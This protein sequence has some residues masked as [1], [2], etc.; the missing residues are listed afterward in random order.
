MPSQTE[1]DRRYKNIRSRMASA[2]LDVLIICGNQYAGFE[3]AVFYASGFEIVHRYVYVLLPLEGEPTLVFPREARWIGDKAKP[4]VKDQ[5]WPDVP[6][7][8]IRDRAKQRRWKRVGVYGMNFIMAVR[9]YRE[10]VQASLELVPFDFE[11]DM[12]RAVKS[13]EELVE[14]R[15]AMDIIVEGF[16]ALVDAYEP[17]KTE[18]EIMAPA[19]ERFFARGAGPRMMNIVLSGAHGQAEAHF[20]VPS[21]RAV[22]SDDLLLYSLEITGAGGYWVEFSRPLLRGKVSP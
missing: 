10:L 15:D 7:R 4:W 9:D 3:G 18:A 2:G 19:V 17:G 22:A 13:E 5:A 21:Q 8:W 1:I 16:W 11:F 12:A 6:G 14:V 20:K